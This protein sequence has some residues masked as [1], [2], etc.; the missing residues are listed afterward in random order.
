MKARVVTIIVFALLISRC[1]FRIESQVSSI[2][3]PQI[4]VKAQPYNKYIM[5]P[6]MQGINPATNL[7]YKQYAEILERTLAT[8]G[9]TKAATLEEAGIVI[10]V[11]YGVGDPKQYNYAMA[12]PFYG[13]TTGPSGSNTTGKFTAYANYGNFVTTTYTPAYGEAGAVFVP[14]SNT[15]YTRF[16]HLEAIDLG[17]YRTEKKVVIVW[18]TTVYS[19]GQSDDLR[20][21]FP[22][23]AKAASRYIAKDSGQVRTVKETRQKNP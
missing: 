6:L 21:I 12:L 2:V 7:P 20:S 22:Y 3:D 23:L 13:Q 8:N 11:A 5:V 16:L 9:F 4:N 19:T 17:K 10:E 14:A 18:K 1:A 15:T